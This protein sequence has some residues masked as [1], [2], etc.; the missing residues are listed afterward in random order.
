M[1]GRTLGS[2]NDLPAATGSSDIPCCC[3]YLS[4]VSLGETS[5]CAQLLPVAALVMREGLS[6]PNGSWWCEVPG[7]LSGL[8]G[9][10]GWARH[11]AGTPGPTGG[12]SVLACHALSRLYSEHDVCLLCSLQG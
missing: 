2:K 7:A 5:V 9:L 8:S 3:F 11:L 4:L 6:F 12:R 1:S 10:A